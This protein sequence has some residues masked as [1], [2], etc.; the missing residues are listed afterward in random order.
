MKKI[1]AVVLALTMI[2][3]MSIPAFAADITKLDGTQDFDV[4]AKYTFNNNTAP[5]YGVNVSW[6]AISFE[7]VVGQGAW[8]PEKLDYDAN[9]SAA[10]KATEATTT[11]TVENR[12]NATIVATAEFEPAITGATADVDDAITLVSA[13]GCTDTGKT[14]TIDVTV[15]V[16]EAVLAQGETS[17]GT[18]TVTITAPTQE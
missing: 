18:I 16:S 1:L 10:W 15:D 14:G 2:V 13:V 12:S 6:T 5:V 17:V 11:I 3:G 7:Y 4:K 8:N 9:A